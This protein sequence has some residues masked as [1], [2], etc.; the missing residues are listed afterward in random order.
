M[1]KERKATVKSL[2]CDKCGTEI[3]E[4]SMKIYPIEHYIYTCPKC[5]CQIISYWKYPIIIYDNIK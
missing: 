3:T 5:S 4:K 1:V 2:Y